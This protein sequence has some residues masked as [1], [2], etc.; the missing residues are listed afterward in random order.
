[1]KLFRFLKDRNERNRE[2][3]LKERTCR[4]K[5][6][7]CKSFDLRNPFPSDLPK[8]CL[9][10][11][12]WHE[13]DSPFIVKCH[14]CEYE[15]VVHFKPVNR[16]SPFTGVDLGAMKMCSKV[17]LPEWK[18]EY[19]LANT[20]PLRE[21]KAEDSYPSWYGITKGEFDFFKAKWLEEQESN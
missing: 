17:G 18:N 7:G 15:T 19:W 13:E 1:M 4:W 3:I 5:G 14:T 9:D 16:F 8:D 10:C 2:R 12:G 6:S 11:R 20:C 21:P